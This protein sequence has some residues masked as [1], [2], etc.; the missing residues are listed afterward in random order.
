MSCLETVAP[1]RMPM[2]GDPESAVETHLGSDDVQRH[3]PWGRSIRLD[4]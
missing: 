1:I 2:G 3:L 4:S